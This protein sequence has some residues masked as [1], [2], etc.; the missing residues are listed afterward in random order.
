M[1]RLA[2]NVPLSERI[3]NQLRQR[4]AEGEFPV[5][6]LLPTEVDL[7]R[8]FDV[9]RGCVR[10]AVRSLV[11]AGMLGARAGYGTFVVATSDLA[12]ALARRLEHDRIADVLEV[13]LLLE[14]EGARLAA[15][16]ATPEQR[17]VLAEALAERAAARD[18]G[19][20][21]AYAEADRRF[22]RAIFEASGNVLLAELYRGAGGNDQALLHLDSPDVDLDALADDIAR[23]D[24]THVELVAA[25]EA[26]DP[27]RAADAA[28]RMVH[29][30]HA[31]AGF[32][33]SQ[34]DQPTA[35]PK[36][37]PAD[38]PEENAR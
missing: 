27:D 31:Q 33:P 1:P 18:T 26:R 11:H 25:I 3:A 35:Q 7:A 14:R 4:I 23:I 13:R 8:E 36:A 19:D 37:Q 2:P 15:T 9:S 20:A 10:E 6:T 5:G 38:Q 16:R 28:E 17:E 21:P 29:V 12:P 34:D 22:H 30:A 32:E 24:A